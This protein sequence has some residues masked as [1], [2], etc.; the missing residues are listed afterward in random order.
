[1]IYKKVLGLSL[2]FLLLLSCSDKRTSQNSYEVI[3]AKIIDKNFSNRGDIYGK[4]E[5]KYHIELKNESNSVVTVFDCG[6]QYLEIVSPQ[7][8]TLDTIMLPPYPTILNP[9]EI[10]TIIARIQTNRELENMFTNIKLK[11]VRSKEACT[12]VPDSLS[13]IYLDSLIIE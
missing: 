3:Q 6:T 13:Y 11:Y 2:L 8:V 1:M 10:D 7:L 5:Y 12:V 9:H 4:Y